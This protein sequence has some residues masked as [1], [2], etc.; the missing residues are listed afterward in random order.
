MIAEKSTTFKL[1]NLFGLIALAIA[2]SGCATPPPSKTF[3]AHTGKTTVRASPVIAQDNLFYR[4][5]A[6]PMHTT[7]AGYGLHTYFS[8]TLG[9]HFFKQ[10][11]SNGKQL[12]FDVLDQDVVGS[13]GVA[14][15]GFIRLSEAEFRKAAK[16]GFDFKLI[17]TKGGVEGS[18]PAT[19]FQQVLA[20]K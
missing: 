8:T 9:W 19:A 7:T 11:W 17:G 3:D 12:K 4:L 10:A 18:V 14:E 2:L 16:S 20:L 5:N 1:A 6:T 15:E 13:L